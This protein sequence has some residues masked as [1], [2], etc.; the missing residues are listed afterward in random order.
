MV[1][2]WVLSWFTRFPKVTKYL[3]IRPEIGE[4]TEQN[5]RSRFRTSKE[6][7]DAS[8]AATASSSAATYLSRSCLLIAPGV[9]PTSLARRLSA[10]ASLSLAS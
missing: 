3:L 8:T 4:I 9:F 5:S 6:A 2:S 7:F 10:L 1:V